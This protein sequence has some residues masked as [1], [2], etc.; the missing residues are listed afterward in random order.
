[1]WRREWDLNPRAPRGHRLAVGHVPGLGPR[2][3]GVV[4]PVPG[5]GIPA[6][7][8]AIVIPTIFPLL[9]ENRLDKGRGRESD[10]AL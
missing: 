5:S 6:C 8:V 2:F 4:C 3:D 9:R 1:M 7:G 10:P